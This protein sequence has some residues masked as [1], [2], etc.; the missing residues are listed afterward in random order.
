MTFTESAIPDKVLKMVKGS[1]AQDLCRFTIK[2]RKLAALDVGGSSGT[3]VLIGSEKL[4]I[5]TWYSVLSI[6]LEL[7]R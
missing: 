4:Q 5:R 7:Q 6:R 1:T 2:G 3:N